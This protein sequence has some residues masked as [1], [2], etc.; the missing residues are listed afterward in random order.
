MEDDYEVAALP[1][2]PIINQIKHHKKMKTRKA[3]AKSYL[4]AIVSP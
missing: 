4:N 1:E 2:N 3:K